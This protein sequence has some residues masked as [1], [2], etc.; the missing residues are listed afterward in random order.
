M[1]LPIGLRAV[2]VAV[3]S[4]LLFVGLAGTATAAPPG[5]GSPDRECAERG[6]PLSKISVQLYTFADYLNSGTDEQA[7][8]EE[9]L[10][11]LAEMGYRNVEPY[12]LSGWT[13]EEYAALLDEYGLKAS[14]RHVDVGSP[15]N[16]AD[17]AQI[18]A[19]NRT[20]GITY[21]G[22]GSTAGAPWIGELETEADWIAYAEY[23]D[24]VGEQARQAGQT[25][26]I[27]NH[28]FEFT[29]VFGD[30]TA[31]DILMQHTQ[32]KNV[33]SQLDLYWVAFAGLD[34]VEVVEEYGKRI[35]LLHVKD[36]NP[37]LENRIEIVGRG[38]LDFPAIF[39]AAHRVRYHVVE[40]DPRFGDPTFDP[41]EAA[42]VGLDYLTSV[43]Y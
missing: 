37:E 12:T 40:H 14:A 24:A 8:H 21:F 34:P 30:R 13:A 10:R 41:F 19:D 43:T 1:K 31:F 2:L 38:S 39:D 42:E 29:T 27:H 26:F 18:I 20:L 16:P 9:V 32:K 11:R 23:L 5:K 28:D 35:Q 33:V 6:V 3:L 25:L 17:I 15:A 7:Q 4:A 22:S 36:L